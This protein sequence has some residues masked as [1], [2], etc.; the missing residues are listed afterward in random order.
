MT[1]GWSIITDLPI[2]RR[3]RRHAVISPAGANVFQSWLLWDCFQWLDAEGVTS[4]TLRA[5]DPR[6]PNTVEAVRAEKES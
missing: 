1:P 3:K 2:T 4:Y 6:Q 5:S